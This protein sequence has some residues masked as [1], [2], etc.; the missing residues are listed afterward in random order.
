VAAAAALTLA[1]SG[2]SA[3]AHYARV[4]GIRMYYESSGHGQALF[5]LHGGGGD[6]TQFAHQVPV[7]SKYFH[8]IVPDARAQGRTTDG[9]GPLSYHAMAEDLFALMSNLH[10]VRAD[11]VGWSD[12][13]DVGL[14]LAIHHPERVKHLVTFGANFAP[15]GYTDDFEEWMNGA[16]ASSFGSAT[17]S[18]YQSV[19]PDPAHYETAMSKILAMWR[20]QP[21]FTPEELGSIRARTLIVAGEHDIVRLAHTEAL[22]RAIPGAHM[23][24]VPGATHSVIF[25][26]TYLVNRMV[27]DF[28]LDRAML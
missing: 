7:F 10:V 23:R 4:N 9:P 24:I 1:C 17:E 11:V 18:A 16:N 26:R 25:E 19:A 12:G 13:G 15:D 8:V 28:L 21:R 6:G 22:S 14:D 5:L 3:R 2:F 20:T 27:L